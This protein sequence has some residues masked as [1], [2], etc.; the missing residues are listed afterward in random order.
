MN[1]LSLAFYIYFV[2]AY[3]SSQDE[4]N[5]M[6]F[7]DVLLSSDIS[8]IMYI[9]FIATMLQ[10]PFITE[11]IVAFL[12][13]SYETKE[14]NIV[15]LK[16]RRTALRA[17][18]KGLAIISTLMFPVWSIIAS[19]S[20]PLKYQYSI[21]SSVP[22]TIV[23]GACINL[24]YCSIVNCFAKSCLRHSTDPPSYPS[25]LTTFGC[26]LIPAKARQIILD[27]RAV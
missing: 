10:L 1:M 19:S 27:M 20:I 12:G 25:S 8:R 6:V 11:P 7:E 14:N 21:A 5:S 15:V 17:L 9:C 23:G 3:N 16:T 26:C 13:D 22:V 2:N 18:V 24:L 4:T